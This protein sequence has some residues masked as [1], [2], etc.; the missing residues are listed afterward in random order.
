MVA[1]ANVARFADGTTRPLIYIKDWDFHWQ[2][3]YTYEDPL[4]L[5]K[6][7]VVEMR[8]VR[9]L[10]HVGDRVLLEQFFDL[11]VQAL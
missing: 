7:T 1:R 4:L 10:I 3:V 2:D 5:P 9:D 11:V 8:R 6:G